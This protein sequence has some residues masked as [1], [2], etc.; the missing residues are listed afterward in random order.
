MCATENPP[1]TFQCVSIFFFQFFFF[2]GAVA[3]FNDFLAF[4]PRPHL[5]HTQTH[6]LTTPHS[7][8]CARS[9]AH[10][11]S[12]SNSIRPL[13]MMVHIRMHAWYMIVRCERIYSFCCTHNDEDDDGDDGDDDCIFPLA[14]AQG[15]CDTKRH[16]NSLQT[17]LM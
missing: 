17:I 8:L 4:P 3:V 15:K 6:L 10:D 16:R 1:K 14:L 5:T 13:Q 9:F 2:F 12:F 11:I 7:L